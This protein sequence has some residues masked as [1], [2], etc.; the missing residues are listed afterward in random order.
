[1]TCGLVNLFEEASP[2]RIGLCL[3]QYLIYLRFTV[4]NKE[5]LESLT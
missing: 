4:F 1:M 5:A 3:L 2:M